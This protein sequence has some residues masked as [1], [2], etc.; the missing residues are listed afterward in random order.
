MADAALYVAIAAAVA[1]GVQTQQTGER[2]S[3]RSERALVRQKKKSA[4]ARSAVASERLA[5]QQRAKE[6]RQEK[7]DSQ[8]I[9]AKAKQ[10]RQQ[11]ETYKSGTGGVNILRGTRYLG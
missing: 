4:I 6:M 3:R 8:A 11:G 2:T 9:L 7:P 1:S 5:S 10:K